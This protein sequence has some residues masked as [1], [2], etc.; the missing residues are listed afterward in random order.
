[1]PVNTRKTTDLKDEILSKT[2]DKISDFELDILALTFKNWSC[3]S[4]QK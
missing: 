1:M 4:I 2:D 3:R